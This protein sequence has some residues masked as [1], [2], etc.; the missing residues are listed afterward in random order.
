MESDVKAG[1]KREVTT[2]QGTLP[3]VT[4]RY[5]AALQSHAKAGTNE[6]CHNPN[7]SIVQGTELLPPSHVLPL[8]TLFRFIH[9][10]PARMVIRA[11]RISAPIARAISDEADPS[12]SRAKRLVRRIADFFTLFSI[13]LTCFEPAEFLTLRHD[14]WQMNEDEYLR[15]FRASAKRSCKRRG[16]GLDTELVPMGDLGYDGATFFTTLDAKYLVKPLSQHSER[17]LFLQKLYCGYVSHMKRHPNSLLVRIT[18][19]VFASHA[20]LAGILG[21][22]P[23][24]HMAM[25]N[26]LYGRDVDGDSGLGTGWESYPLTPTNCYPFRPDVQGGSLV[27]D[28]VR[29]KLF[30]EFLDQICVTAQMKNDLI[31]FLDEDTQ[32]L[33]AQGLVDYSLFIIRFPSLHYRQPPRTKATAHPWRSGV[34]DVSGQ[35]TYRV[36]ILDFFCTKPRSK[37]AKETPSPREYRQRFMEM[38]DDSITASGR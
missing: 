17:Q 34:R 19:V 4:T 28:S 3:P 22:V 37:R 11:S 2:R 20:S 21:T 15:S 24:H 8:P 26:L 33:S 25:E 10:F 6:S 16:K 14:V 32:F 18:D 38:V 36:A 29:D 31:G 1:E 27:T 35:W 13:R 7:P 23:T 9:Q 12:R 5:A 30:D